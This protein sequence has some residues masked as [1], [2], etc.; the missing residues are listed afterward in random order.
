MHYLFLA[1]RDL[2]KW[3]E[4]MRKPFEELYGAEYFKSQWNQ[5]VDAYSSYLHK[6]A[7][8]IVKDRIHEIKKPTLIVHGQVCIPIHFAMGAKIVVI[9]DYYP[10]T[11]HLKTSVLKQHNLPF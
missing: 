2:D 4:R 5:W 9:D 6:H 10:R 11:L 3:S 1:L 7:G 8:D